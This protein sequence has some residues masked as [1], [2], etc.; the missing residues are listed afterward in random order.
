MTPLSVLDRHSA[1]LVALLQRLVLIPT[2]N[3]P[4]DH[5]E[6]ITALLTRELRGAGL[7]ARRIPF[8]DPRQKNG[9]VPNWRT[10]P[11]FNVIGY[12]ATG[13]TKTLHFNAPL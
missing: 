10:H 9:R 3:P 6:T 2:V 13:A 1:D 8:H 12:R 4:G 5:Y 7:Q 11:R